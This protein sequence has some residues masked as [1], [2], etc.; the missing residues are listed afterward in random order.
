M[1]LDSLPMKVC[2]LSACIPGDF[3]LCVGYLEIVLWYCKSC[4]DSLKN[5]DRFILVNS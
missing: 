5:I 2:F 4:L 3:G 1:P